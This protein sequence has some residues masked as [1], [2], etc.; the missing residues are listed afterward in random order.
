MDWMWGVGRF[1]G[2]GLMAKVG[3]VGVVVGWLGVAGGKMANLLLSQQRFVMSFQWHIGQYVGIMER[4]CGEWLF[5]CLVRIGGKGVVWGLVRFG[6][7]R[8]EWR[9]D[10]DFFSL[11]RSR[12]D[13]L[14]R[15]SIIDRIGLI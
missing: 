13:G 10:L 6:Q 5:V 8:F 15:W 3:L 14:T 4:R 11:E 7:L 9:A 12:W 1:D 2:V